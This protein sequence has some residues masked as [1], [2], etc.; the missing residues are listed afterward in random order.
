MPHAANWAPATQELL[1]TGTTT[2]NLTCFR[3][4]AGTIVFLTAARRFGNTLPFLIQNFHADFAA[5]VLVVEIRAGQHQLCT[6][7]V[8]GYAAAFV[9]I[10]VIFGP[11]LVFPLGILTAARESEANSGSLQR[12]SAQFC[13]FFIDFSVQFTY[14]VIHAR[15]ANLIRRNQMAKK[16]KAAKKPAKAAAKPKR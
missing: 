14:K 2:T 5:A 6:P 10:S 9:H 3:N 16:A 13:E 7:P 15:G 4:H 12:K 11:V 1:R 8:H